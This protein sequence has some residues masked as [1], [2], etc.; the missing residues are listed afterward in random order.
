MSTLLDKWISAT[1]WMM[2]TPKAYG[3]L[4]LS[5][6]VIGFVICFLLAKHLAGISDRSSRRM[7]VSIGI[8]LLVTEVYKQLFYYYC[9]NDNH[10]A[11]W[12]FPFQL[13]SIPMYLCIIA[14]LLKPGPAQ[15]GMYSFMMIYNLLGGGIAFIEP[16]GLLH[17]YL[18]LTVHALLW[19][20]LLVFVGF[21]LM[22]SGKG[23]C[24]AEDYIA[25]TKTF[26]MLCVIAFLINHVVQEATGAG[27]NMFFV[28]PGNSSIIVFKQISERFGW[29]FSTLL[30]VP[31]VCIGAYLLFLLIRAYQTHTK[32]KKQRC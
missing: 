11:W 25:A 18:T 26:L 10:Y 16:S 14:P 21:Y 12:I 28:G 31:V 3:P 8:F 4:H 30:Y 23:G 29:Y 19:H 27:I 20:M 6:T 9:V 13:C 2:T 22:F 7:L 15:K 24:T 1:G 5:F 17:P 32:A